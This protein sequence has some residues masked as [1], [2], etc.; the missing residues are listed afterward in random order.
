MKKYLKKNTMKLCLKLCLA[1]LCLCSTSLRVLGGPEL[2][3]PSEAPV[4]ICRDLSRSVEICR[5]L[6]I[7]RDRDLSVICQA[8]SADL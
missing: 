2:L 5:D 1:D 3:L 7:C 4:E 8:D 6:S